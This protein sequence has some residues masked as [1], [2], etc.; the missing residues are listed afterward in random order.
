MVPLADHAT[1]TTDGRSP[2]EDKTIHSQTDCDNWVMLTAM[3]GMTC[4]Q[5]HPLCIDTEDA[6]PNFWCPTNWTEFFQRKSQPIANNQLGGQIVMLKMAPVVTMIADGLS[7]PL[8]I[9]HGLI[10]AYGKE[11]V[12]GMKDIIIHMVGAGVDEIRS[13]KRYMEISHC[14]PALR[15]LKIVMVGPWL[16]FEQTN[17][18]I[19]ADSHG[20]REYRCTAATHDLVKSSYEDYMN[21]DAAETPT[22]IIA[23]HSGVEEHQGA[24]FASEWDPAVALMCDMNVPC[25]FT[26]YTLQESQ[27]GVC[28]LQNDVNITQ[29]AT[30]NP[31]RGLGPLPDSA[32]AGWYFANAAY[33]MFQG[34]GGGSR[35]VDLLKK[36]RE[37][38]SSGGGQSRASGSGSKEQDYTKQSENHV[39]PMP[40][41]V[42]QEFEQADLQ[43]DNEWFRKNWPVY[44][45][46]MGGHALMSYPV[47]KWAGFQRWLAANPETFGTKI[48]LKSLN[49]RNPILSTVRTPKV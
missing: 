14:L 10:L 40:F 42:Q 16:P 7:T 48:L 24:N 28:R 2:F 46:G 39:H 13:V 45:Q 36:E 23:Q 27:D 1:T 32:H 3:Q 19:G 34:F 6:E 30:I 49:R 47:F 17:E 15:R 12:E 41:E 26:G 4:E 33:F 38:T 44:S 37:Q 20:V 9:V 25:L 35:L 11:K 43:A 18:S 8:T 22:F 5:E 29:E 31:L 21:T